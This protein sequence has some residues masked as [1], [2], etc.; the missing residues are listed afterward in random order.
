M[1]NGHLDEKTTF[2]GDLAHNKKKKSMQTFVKS[3]AEAPLH[4]PLALK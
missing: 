4:L 3:K 2:T 1:W